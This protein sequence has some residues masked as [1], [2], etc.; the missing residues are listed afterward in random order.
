M[1]DTAHTPETVDRETA[2]LKIAPHSIEAELAILGGLL[3]NN[4]VWEHVSER[5]SEDDF[6]RKDHRMI[7]HAIAAL[8]NEG[9]PYDVVTVAE[10]LENH[11][12]LDDAGGLTFLATLAEKT[13]GVS[14]VKAYADIV[15]KRSVLRQLIQAT[16]K[17]SETVYN[18]QGLTNEQILD[19]AEQAVFEIAENET[20]GRRNYDTIKDLLV[21][22]LDKID[23]LFHRDSPITGVATGYEDLD[24]KTAGLQP[25]DLIIIAGRPS[26]GKTS[27]AINIA[28]HAVIKD[29]LAVVVFSMEMPGDSLAMRMMSSLGR[30]DQHK[31]RTGK[32]ADE[33]WPRLT[34]AVE[35]LKD[36]RL[37]IDDTPALT[38]SEIRARCRRIYR[39]NNGLDLVIIDYLQLMQVSGTTENRAT[40]ISE[41]S[42]SLKA[43]AKELKV[44][45]VALSQLN[46]SLEARPNK[47]PVMSDLRESG[48]IEQ[49]ADLIMFIY[50]DVVYN[51][52]TTD[53]GKAELIIAK[54]RNGPI[55]MVP[56]TFLGQYTR[57]ENYIP[58]TNFPSSGGG[59]PGGGYE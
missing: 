6:Y 35:I 56:L 40:E 31:V 8:D 14:N 42:R 41:I 49:D 2:S 27:L 5:V 18:P 43:M 44:P 48:A 4:S 24:E 26:M 28:E 25:S 20:K 47:R 52:D 36:S 38:P 50:R 9:Q 29:K 17:I 13:P 34:S 33:D 59:F 22:A 37:F 58:D 55:G 32:L 15:R 23:E 39:E 30:I 11:Q 16:S 3:I 51:E 21:N 12:Q 7:F 54:Q 1:Q 19:S 57:F 46:R 10:W 45:V 53:K